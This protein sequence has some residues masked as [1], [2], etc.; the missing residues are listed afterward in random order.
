MIAIP[1]F[2]GKK[3][4]L[5]VK[6]LPEGLKQKLGKTHEKI[7][8]SLEA[9]RP[10]TEVLNLA[11]TDLAEILV[12]TQTLVHEIKRELDV[13][14]SI[15]STLQCLCYGDQHPGFIR[16]QFYSLFFLLLFFCLLPLRRGL[17]ENFFVGG[18]LELMVFSGAGWCVE[19]PC[20]MCCN[21]NSI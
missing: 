12:S 1:F 14:T 15:P 20:K 13:K 7:I 6:I 17:K 4:N 19:S 3:V 21:Q 8:K 18:F 10:F 16:W 2:K 5:M 11:G 9:N